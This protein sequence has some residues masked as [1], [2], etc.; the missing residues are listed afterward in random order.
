MGEMRN[1]Y[2]YS[3]RKILMK[4]SNS[5][6]REEKKNRKMSRWRLS[7]DYMSIQQQVAFWF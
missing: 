5:E 1:V 3:G 2:R 7:C 6:D 4:K